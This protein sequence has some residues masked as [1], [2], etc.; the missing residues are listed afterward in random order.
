MGCGVDART[1]PT[2]ESETAPSTKVGLRVAGAAPRAVRASAR[3]KVRAVYST[4]A[5]AL[6]GQ[7]PVASFVQDL[8]I[9][10]T[11]TWAAVATFSGPQS[12]VDANDL[13]VA[14]VDGVEC[15][16]APAASSGS[17]AAVGAARG[18]YSA[19]FGY[20]GFPVAPGEYEVRLR[21]ARAG[22]SS[23]HGLFS[24]ASE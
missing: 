23:A 8:N 19:L 15:L 7:L 10:S 5:S 12:G 22:L 18:N 21:Q 1:V 16:S 3:A 2:L 6:D 9:G 11:T 24:L 13:C 20:P 17:S 4:D 14:E